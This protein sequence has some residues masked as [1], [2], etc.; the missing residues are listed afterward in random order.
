MDISACSGFTPQQ[1]NNF[2]I[3]AANY[4]GSGCVANFGMDLCAQLNTT[5]VSSLPVTSFAFSSQCIEKMAPNTFSNITA[6]QFAAIQN[7]TCSAFSPGLVH[8]LPPYVSPK[9]T[10]KCLKNF[11]VEACVA[12]TYNFALNISW[13]T[14]KGFSAECLMQMSNETILAFDRKAIGGI[15]AYAFYGM[16]RLYLFSMKT[17]N[18]IGSAQWVMIGSN[19]GGATALGVMEVLTGD[20]NRVDPKWVVP[21][22]KNAQVANYWQTDG[23]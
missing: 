1:M 19:L 18:A 8:N 21:L 2:P 13:D 12:M 3:D 20:V 15:D 22:W 17:L 9:L 23:K 10:A 14:M 7:T 6:A 4:F 11:T 5:F 16:N